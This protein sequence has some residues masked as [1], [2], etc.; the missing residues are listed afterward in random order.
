MQDD[1][2]KEYL[3]HMEQAEYKRGGDQT[4]ES[5]V[6]RLKQME[7]GMCVCCDKSNQILNGEGLC[8]D[9]FIAIWSA[10]EDA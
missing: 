6:F 3:E 10:I 4:P 9:C 7:K 8:V 1:H 2:I 5:L